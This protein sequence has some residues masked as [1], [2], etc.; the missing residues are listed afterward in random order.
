MTPSSRRP[1]TAARLL[2]APAGRLFIGLAI[3]A[4]AACTDGYPKEDEPF[5]N[6]FDMDRAQLIDAMNDIG[7]DAF[8]GFSWRYRLLDECVLAISRRAAGRIQDSFEVPLQGRVVDLQAHA[9]G[10]GYAVGVVP[11]AGESPVAALLE[12]SSRMDALRMRLLTQGM[13]IDC[14]DDAAPA[15]EG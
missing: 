11:A 9:A 3:V 2:N 13:Q 12:T 6:P 8:A 14:L 5:L 15:V 10:D 1:T 7:H 4:S